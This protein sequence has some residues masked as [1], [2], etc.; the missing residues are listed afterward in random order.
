M[1]ITYHNDL[2][3]GSDEW[4]AARCGLITGS[5][6][7]YLI[8]PKTLKPLNNDKT[9]A[10]IWELAAQRITNYVEPTYIGDDM[11]RGHEDEIAAR[12]LYSKHFQPVTECGFVTNDRWGFT[13]GCSP[14]GLVGDAGMIECK[15]RRQKF[16]IQTIVEHHR[17]GTIP[18]DFVMQVQTN[19][20]VTERSWID[21]ISFSGGLPM[22]P[23]TVEADREIQEAIEAA[24]TEAE[25]QIASAMADFQEAIARK[26]FVP[27]ERRVEHEMYI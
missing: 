5:E 4:H 19:L 9:R 25:R 17:M 8:S 3:Q 16:Q 10:H 2:I 12:D 23:I 24:T 26:G 6:V 18:E 1:S 15:S 11:L 7:K 21:F 14:D 13:L 20:L 22:R 27:T